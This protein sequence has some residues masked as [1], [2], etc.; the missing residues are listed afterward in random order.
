MVDE[1]GDLK[2]VVGANR[3][4]FVI[5]SRSIARASR[6][7]KRMLF[8]GFR[9]S[10][11]TAE[12]STPWV[13][14]LPEDDPEAAGL[15]LCIAHSRFE[16][17]PASLTLAELHSLLVFS[18]KYDMTRLIRP[19][20]QAWVPQPMVW[21]DS[22]DYGT[23]IGIAWELGVQDAFLDIVKR[24]VV[25]CRVDANGQ[26]VGDDQM[27]IEKL[28]MPLIPNGYFE[29][30]A[31]HRLILLN[32]IFKRLRDVIMQLQL[33]IPTN[34]AHYCTYPDA[35]PDACHAMILGSIVSG[36]G[37]LELN[38]IFQSEE[39]GPLY[40]PSINHLISVVTAISVVYIADI[41]EDCNPLPKLLEGY[42]ELLIHVDLLT[43]EHIVHLKAQQ[44]KLDIPPLVL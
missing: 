24:M 28:A 40:L 34:S 42:R 22:A 36:L 33:S 1:D 9:E 13:V 17:T 25:E 3:R 44:E 14:D 26:L 19:W 23:M 31:N 4:E 11:P 39:E 37:L 7:F 5:C 32:E 15:L 10:R 27:P 2:L 41:H 29:A 8:G 38:I 18:E 12:I 30:I 20:V 21:Q 6:V 43:A 16:N 35:R